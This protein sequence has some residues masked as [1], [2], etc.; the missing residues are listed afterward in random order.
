M[1]KKNIDFLLIISIFLLAFLIV[2]F[3]VFL[4][5]YFNTPY[6]NISKD[7]ISLLNNKP[8]FGL[9]SNMGA[10]FWSFA[11][12]VCFFTFLI[13][14][15]KGD[16]KNNQ[17]FV[18]LGG[19]IS[20]VLLF[21]DF[22]MFHEVIFSWLFNL[23]ELYLFS[24]Y[25][26]IVLFYLIKFQKIILNNN[27]IILAVSLLLFGTSIIVDVLPESSSTHHHFFEDVP[28]FTGIVSW[29]CFHLLVCKKL[30]LEIR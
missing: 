11:V 19:I 12:S 4:S 24:F 8:Y 27:Y 1:I 15:Q 14:K 20:L 9:L 13:L 17:S 6:S 5:F 22:F 23:N 18:L 2:G 21:D 29:F 10:I 26:V 16:T 7:P 25:G 30:L 28:K 3:T